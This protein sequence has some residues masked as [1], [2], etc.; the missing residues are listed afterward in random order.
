[1]KIAII[2]NSHL[3][4]LKVAVRD[5]LFRA[6]QLDVTFWGLAG[7]EFASITYEGGLFQTQYKHFALQVSEGRYDSLPVHEFDAII[8]HGTLDPGLY[9]DSLRTAADDLRC[10]SSACLREGLQTYIEND[11]TWSLVRSLRTDYDRRVLMSPIP[12]KSDFSDQFKG[13]SITADEFN[14]LNSHI[15]ATLCS[16]GGKYIVQPSATVCDY[17]YTKREFCVHS[18]RLLGDL[19]IKHPEDDYIHM[20]GQYGACVLNDINAQLSERP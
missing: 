18:V 19:A 11:P 2:G 6:D 13:R 5:G 16:V 10:Y 12:L 8:F 7:P 9:L 15:G 20:N 4:A 1:M 3:A 17:K 14:I